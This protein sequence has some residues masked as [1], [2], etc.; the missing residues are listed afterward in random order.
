MEG[1]RG[2]LANVVPLFRIFQLVKLNLSSPW[3]RLWKGW[4]L[5]ENVD[6]ADPGLKL[7]GFPSRARTGISGDPT[8]TNTNNSISSRS[9]LKETSAELFKVKP[10]NFPSDFEAKEKRREWK[11]LPI[12]WPPVS[13]T[14]QTNNNCNKQISHTNFGTSSWSHLSLVIL[15]FWFGFIVSF[16]HI[17]TFVT[18]WNTFRIQEYV[19]PAPPPPPS[20]KKTHGMG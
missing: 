20:P 4:F 7:R 3:R 6:L 16:S 19:I 12:E 14:G 15:T 18:V 17:C 8:N 2:V 1:G 5:A 11:Q 10:L 9:K 13:N